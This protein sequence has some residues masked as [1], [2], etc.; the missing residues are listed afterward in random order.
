MPDRYFCP[1]CERKTVVVRLMANAGEDN[2]RCTWHR[3]MH[4]ACGWWVFIEGS[5]AE[6]REKMRSFKARNWRAW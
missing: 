5:S 3:H 4:D 6:D 1:K 2:Y